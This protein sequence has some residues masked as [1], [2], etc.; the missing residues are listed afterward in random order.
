[1]GGTTLFECRPF[2]WE[3]RKPPIEGGNSVLKILEK[4]WG[5]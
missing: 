5:N 2:F 1:M 3:K 4:I